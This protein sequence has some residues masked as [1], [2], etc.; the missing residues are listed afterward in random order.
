MPGGE[1]LHHAVGDRDEVTADGPVI[2]GKFD[3]LG[4]R[5]ERRPAGEEAERVVAEEAH[6]RHLRAGGKAVGNVVGEPDLPAGSDAVEG[7]R[8]RGL[9]RRQPPERGLGG[10]G[11]AVGNHDH[12]LHP[13]W[14]PAW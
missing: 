3:P 9:E 12:V 7:R 2:G 10:I 13:H 4:S 1:I 6:A 8:L 5:F 11:G 14:F